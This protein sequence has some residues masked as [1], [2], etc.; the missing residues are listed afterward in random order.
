MDENQIYIACKKC[1][2]FTPIEPSANEYFCPDCHIKLPFDKETYFEY[3]CDVCQIKNYIYYQYE[4]FGKFSF[5]CKKCNYQTKLSLGEIIKEQVTKFSKKLY[6]NVVIAGG[7]VL[8]TIFLSSASKVEEVSEKITKKTC[9]FERKVNYEE[10]IKSGHAKC[11]MKCRRMNNRVVRYIYERGNENCHKSDFFSK[12][13][14]P[15][16]A[17]EGRDISVKYRYRP[18]NI[19]IIIAACKEPVLVTVI[20]TS[21]KDDKCECR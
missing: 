5:Q 7:G 6:R 12:P 19:R 4:Y 9:K 14:C 16:Y 20:N 2:K 18:R 17:L 15:R 11:R 3:I 10:V 13:E 8:I 1:K 21:Y